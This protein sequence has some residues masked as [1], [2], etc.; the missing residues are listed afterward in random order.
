[1]CLVQIYIIEKCSHILKRV[2]LV[3]ALLLL[4]ECLFSFLR[5]YY[6]ESLI[7]PICFCE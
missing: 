5:K 2:S 1:M 6:N 4:L 7:E 3:G